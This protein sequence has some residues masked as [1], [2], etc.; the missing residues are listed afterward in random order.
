MSMA[1]EVR[2]AST[3]ASSSDDRKAGGASSVQEVRHPVA[4]DRH[5]VA[6][7]GQS[8]A[9]DRH[10]VAKDRGEKVGGKASPKPDERLVQRR[11]SEVRFLCCMQP[12]VAM[13]FTQSL[14]HRT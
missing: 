14:C 6:K 13:L 5:P 12:L 10:P 4:K 11:T 3:A 8:A 1:A 9:S 7:D 2:A